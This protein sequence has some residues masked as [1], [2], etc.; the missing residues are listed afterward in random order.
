MTLSTTTNIDT[1]L[2]AGEQVMIANSERN[3]QR[4]LFT[5]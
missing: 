1:L 2:F 4:G 3:L 5:L